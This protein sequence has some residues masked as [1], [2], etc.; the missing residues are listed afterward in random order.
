MLGRSMLRLAL[1]CAGCFQVTW[2]FACTKPEQCVMEDGTRGVCLAGTCHFGDLSVTDDLSGADLVGVDFAGADLA[3]ADLAGADLTQPA[4]PDLA[5]ADLAPGA[6]CAYPQLLVTV[7]KLAPGNGKV[8]RYHLAAGGVMTGC[9][10]LTG[11]G[12]LGQYPEA[13]AKVGSDIAVAARDGVFLI[14]PATDLV[15]ASWP[16]NPNVLFP[17]DVA[18]ISTVDGPASAVAWSQVG[19]PTTLWQIDLF[20]PSQANTPKYSYDANTLG[21]RAVLGMTGHPWDATKLMVLDDYQSSTPQAEEY[22]DP[23]GS[24]VV[25]KLAEPSGYGFHSIATVVVGGLER[26]VWTARNLYNGYYAGNAPSPGPGISYG[27]AKCGCD[28]LHAVPDPTD[29]LGSFALCDG[30]GTQDRVVHHV[31]WSVTPQTAACSP[32]LNGTSLGADDRITHL[33]IA[34]P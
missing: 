30:G 18:P 2:E 5:G 32:L 29:G 1:L 4:Q 3:G 22:V 7:E 16:N 33:A 17:I 31:V 9:Q 13:A 19:D 23:F 10:T 34:M 8:L 6:V 24:S 26:T 20:L 15:K 11:Q 21:L 25:G 12:A 27:P 28:M 14:D